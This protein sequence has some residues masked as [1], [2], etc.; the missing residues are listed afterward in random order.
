MKKKLFLLSALALMFAGGIFWSCQKDDVLQ[1]ADGVMLKSATSNY[2][3]SCNDVCID[4]SLE[5]VI[6]YKKSGSFNGII[7][8]N[9][10]TIGYTVYNTEDNFV[11]ELSYS[12]T[13]AS[14]SSTS[15]IKVTVDGEEKSTTIANGASDKLEFPLDSDWAG[16][17]E[18]EW[19]LEETEYD[20]GQIAG[21][22]TYDLIGVCGDCENELTTELTICEG[23]KTLTVT[24]RAEEAGDVVIQGGLTNDA[25]IISATSNLLTLNEN[26]P[27]AGG[28]SSV[29]R[30]EGEVDACELV[31]IT[32]VF[33]GGNGVGDWT[34][35]RG[36]T[37]LDEADSIESATQDCPE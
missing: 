15:T 33:T 24:F 14:S 32:I 5:T 8:S 16:C 28:S 1:V 20:G 3:E 7:G 30:W 11:V 22:G 2:P 36:D 12:R 29:T 23:E 21:G 27:S 19:S 9:S 18:V 26:H 17:D 13:P 25:V 37:T 6:Y 10:K 4:L 35:K 34:A 31:T